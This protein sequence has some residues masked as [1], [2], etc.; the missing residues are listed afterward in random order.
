M[1]D[2]RRDP[3]FHHLNSDTNKMLTDLD[4]N[5]INDENGQHV[6]RITKC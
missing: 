3:N 4:G 1:F 6:R 5:V 2:I